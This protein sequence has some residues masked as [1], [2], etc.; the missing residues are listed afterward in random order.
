[1]HAVGSCYHANPYHNWNHAVQVLPHAPADHYQPPETQN[2]QIVYYD[3][4]T[5]EIIDPCQIAGLDQQECYDAQAL[6]DYG[7]QI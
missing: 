1:M 5:D 2:Q 4:I 3:L 7:L 6:Q